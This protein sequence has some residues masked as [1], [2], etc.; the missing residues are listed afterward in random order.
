MDDERAA[1]S[2]AAITTWILNNEDYFWEFSDDLGDNSLYLLKPFAEIVCTSRVMIALGY[3]N[4]WEKLLNCAWVKSKNGNYLADLLIARPDLLVLSCIYADFVSIG[5]RSERLDS[6]ISAAAITKSVRAMELPGWR[7]MDLE[8][9]LARIS[10]EEFTCNDLRQTWIGR[11]P[12]PWIISNDIAYAITHVL[13]Y[14]T[15]FGF[16]NSEL[17]SDLK[18][19]LQLWIPAWIE[20]YK[21]KLNFDLISE[22]VMI[23]SCAKVEINSEWIKLIISGQEKDGSVCGPPTAGDALLRGGDTRKRKKFVR[24]Y[25]TTIVAA[26][27]LGMYLKRSKIH[28]CVLQFDI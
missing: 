3:E 14:I 24:N 13:F 21:R 27:A 25:H 19:Y 6:V 2:L 28:S 10:G 20:I 22:F 9:S 8:Y 4:H 7:R 26:M 5:Y 15:D 12:E 16:K 17:R 11:T 1:A 18:D 23:A